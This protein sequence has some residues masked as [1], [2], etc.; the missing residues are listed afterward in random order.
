MNQRQRER[1]YE[2]YV[3]WQLNKNRY[4]HECIAYT[5]IFVGGILFVLF[6]LSAILIGLGII[7]IVVGCVFSA[8]IF[9]KWNK[10]KKGREELEKMVRASSAKDICIDPITKQI[11]FTLPKE[12]TESVLNEFETAMNKKGLKLNVSRSSKEEEVV[13][14]EEKVN[15]MAKTTDTGYVNRNNQRNNGRSEEVGTDNNQWFYN[16]E[17][18]N[19]GMKYKANGSDIFQRKCPACQGGRP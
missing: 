6:N 18:L 10:M 17:C 3:Q 8:R 2:Y 12:K 13:N 1:S 5:I 15:T 7:M 14:K 4:Q 19:C 16:M 11:S 9:M